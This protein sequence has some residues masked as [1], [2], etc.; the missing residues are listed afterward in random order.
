VEETP[1]EGVAVEGA[2]PEEGAE[3]EKE[4]EVEKK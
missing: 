3:K 2:E 1:A 4:G